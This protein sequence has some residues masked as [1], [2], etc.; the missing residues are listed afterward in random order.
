MFVDQDLKEHS[1]IFRALFN[2]LANE[3]QLLQTL[4]SRKIGRWSVVLHLKGAR[5]LHHKLYQ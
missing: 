1:L 3:E 2:Y 5:E 4:T